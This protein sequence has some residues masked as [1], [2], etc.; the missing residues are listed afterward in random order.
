MVNSLRSLK[1]GG[2]KYETARFLS[3]DSTLSIKRP[4][5]SITFV[6]ALSSKISE[7]KSCA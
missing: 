1:N 7:E 5:W 4:E 3:N 2:Y 6:L